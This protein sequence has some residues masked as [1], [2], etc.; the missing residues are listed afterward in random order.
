MI[1]RCLKC[2]EQVEILEGE[3]VKT[4]NGRRMLKGKCKCGTVVCKFLKKEE[5]CDI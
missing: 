3:I 5:E 4:K 2:Q 1:G